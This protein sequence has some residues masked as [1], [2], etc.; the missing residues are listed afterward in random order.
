MASLL[1]KAITVRITTATSGYP[2]VTRTSDP[3]PALA[4]GQ[5]VVSPVPSIVGAARTGVT[6][7]AVTGAWSPTATLRYQ[8]LSD[9]TPIPGATAATYKVPT[10]MVGTQLSVRVTASRL[11]F[12]PGVATSAPTALVVAP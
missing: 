11:G 3:T 5:F 8:W 1:G 6:L 12:E 7:K 9:S 2:V 4:L 10:S